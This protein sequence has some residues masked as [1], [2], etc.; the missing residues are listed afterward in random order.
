MSI[1]LQELARVCRACIRDDKADVD[2]VRSVG[3]SRYESLL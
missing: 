1:E 2:I 3:E